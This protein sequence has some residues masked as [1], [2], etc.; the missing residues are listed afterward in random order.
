M[1]RFILSSEKA[2]PFSEYNPDENSL[3]FVHDLLIDQ[4]ASH[5]MEKICYVTSLRIFSFSIF[6]FEFIS[7]RLVT[8]I[9]ERHFKPELVKLSFNKCANY[10]VQKILLRITSAEDISSAYDEL[11]PK[12][13]E[14]ISIRISFIFNEWKINF[15]F[16]SEILGSSGVF[17]KLFQRIQNSPAPKSKKS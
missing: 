3:N 17:L 16:E 7:P 4:S 2:D 1:K 9:Y 13:P 5:L 10:C 6:K 15:H 12:F 11:F 8:K 14:L